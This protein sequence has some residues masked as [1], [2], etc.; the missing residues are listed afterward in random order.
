[1][2]HVNGFFSELRRRTLAYIL[3]GESGARLDLLDGL[4]ARP[5]P[6]TAALFGIARPGTNPAMS[7]VS[8]R[9]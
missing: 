4:L 1:M 2:M 9:S 8:R 5:S 6:I 7:R 3:V